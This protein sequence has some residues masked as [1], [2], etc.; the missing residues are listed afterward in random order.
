MR[1][2]GDAMNPMLVKVLVGSVPV[3]L[4]LLYSVAVLVTRKAMSAVLQLVGATCLVVV[5]LS[6]FAEALHRSR[7]CDGASRIAWGTTSICP[8][9]YSA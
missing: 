9:P 6:H 2:N 5:V 1:L 3:F 4:L 8:A 7:R